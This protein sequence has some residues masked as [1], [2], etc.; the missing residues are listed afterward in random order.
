MSRIN[1]LPVGLQSFLESKNFGDNPSEL[2]Q[3]VLPTLDTAPFFS[4]YD[5]DSVLSNQANVNNNG[6]IAVIETPEGRI[7]FL[8]T[9][10]VGIAQNGGML[11]GEKFEVGVAIDDVVNTD[12]PVPDHPLVN[13]VTYEAFAAGASTEAFYGHTFE[14]PIPLRGGEVV[15]FKAQN[16]NGAAGNDCQVRVGI[17]FFEY[18]V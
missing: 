7:R 5:L 1:K 14:S 13:V 3:T 16:H 11:L 12:N 17:R 15:R 4:V 8:Q 10:M 2:A 9:V 6:T 18:S